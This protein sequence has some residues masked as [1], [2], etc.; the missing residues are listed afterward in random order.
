MEHQPISRWLRARR[1][2]A[3]G[4]GALAVLVGVTAGTA[5]PASAATTAPDPAQLTG[6][7]LTSVSNGRGLDV[8]NGNTG[9]GVFLVTNSAPGYHQKWSANL[10]TDGSFTL[11]NDDTGKCATAG[12]PLTQQP[13]DGRGGERWYF[14]PVADGSGAFMVRSVQDDKCLDVWYNAQYNDAWTDTYG[15]NGS[16]AQQWRLPAGAQQAAVAAAVDR[17][18][19]R[20]VKDT[21]SCSW[22]TRVQAPAAPLPQQCVSP[23][24]YNGTTAAVPWTFSMKRTTGWGSE[25]G[26]TLGSDLGTGGASP[27]TAKI[28]TQIS[29]KVTQ[30]LTDELG[31]SLTISVPPAQYGW[32]ALAEL[33]TKVTGT[34]TFDVNGYPWTADDTLTV[35]LLS[36]D[37]GGASIYLAR[38]SDTFS[39]CGG[40]S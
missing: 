13:C 2:A 33:A 16:Q 39:G 12:L 21:S 9:D 20:C 24:W 10:G 17:A 32:V 6:L 5:A 3:V 4:L 1:A 22:R 29:G 34:W 7:T 19:A 40:A 8:Q 11:V 38:T 28:S 30:S 36:D 35:P 25:L 37:Q 18:A 31:N 15:C 27:V 14:Q 23:V 26:F